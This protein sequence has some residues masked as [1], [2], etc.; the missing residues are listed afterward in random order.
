MRSSFS[1][2]ASGDRVQLSVGP[3]NTCASDTA[4]AVADLAL[5]TTALND[6]S[7]RSSNCGS[8]TSADGNSTGA[9]SSDHAGLLVA[10]RRVEV[11]TR[12]TAAAA[13]AVRAALDSVAELASCSDTQALAA[14]AVAVAA[15]TATASEAFTAHATALQQLHSAQQCATGDQDV[16]DDDS[17]CP[18]L[19]HVASLYGSSKRRP[20]KAAHVNN[21]SSSSC[22]RNCSKTCSSVEVLQQQ[23]KHSL[24]QQPKQ[25]LQPCVHCNTLTKKRCKRCQVVYYCSVECQT[26]CFKDPQHRAQCETAAAAATTTVSPATPSIAAAAH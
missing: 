18:P 21:S 13:I 7:S 8:S 6:G 15:A 10:E 25:S 12:S 9:L 4:A 24:Q 26:E 23:P 22:T 19:A 3:A 20:V 14:A 11:T 17:D 2:A 16:S 1:H 5:E